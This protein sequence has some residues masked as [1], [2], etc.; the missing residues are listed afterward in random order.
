[1]ICRPKDQGGLGI[2][3]LQIKNRCL[4]SKWLSKL[5]N[6]EGIWQ[7]L[8]HNKY[9]SNNTLAEVEAK[10]TDSPFWKGLMGVKDNFFNRGHYELGDGKTIRFWEDTCLGDNPLKIQY[11]SLYNISNQKN[12]SVY[13][14]LSNAPPLNMSF[15]RTLPGDNWIEWPHLCLRLICSSTNSGL[16]CVESNYLWGFHCQI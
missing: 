10:H 5:L 14:V 9:L 12:V 4:L 8:L 7:E 2:E 15:R 11:S 1:M 16:F 3:V 13:D 6:E